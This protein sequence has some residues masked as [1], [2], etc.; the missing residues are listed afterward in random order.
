ML[1]AMRTSLP[2]SGKRS[3]AYFNDAIDRLNYVIVPS[4]LTSYVL[5]ISAHMF[6]FVGDEPVRCFAGP[7]LSKSENAFA[8][9]GCSHEQLA[10]YLWVPATLILQAVFFCLPYFLWISW[11]TH[12]GIDFK[13]FFTQ[14]VRLRKM[15][16][17]DSQRTHASEAIAK[18]VSEALIETP[19]LPFGRDLGFYATGLYA[20]V[21]LLYFLNVYMQ[22]VALNTFLGQ[23][24]PVFPTFTFCE[25]PVLRLGGYHHYTLHCHL[26]IND[27]NTKFYH[28]LWW[29]FLPVAFF[30]A[31]SLMYYLI[32]FLA[33]WTCERAVRHLLK[34]TRHRALVN[35]EDEKSRKLI[36]TFAECG[37]RRDGALLFWFI[38][39]EYAA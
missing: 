18:H 20:F 34:D 14:A 23:D 35:D 29:G 15:P 7:E 3:G 32:I 37:F 27:Y 39:G 4:V 30:N 2:D 13:A 1:V 11:R 28:F 24:S 21:K 6:G 16:P 12:S 8:V 31:T 9:G 17:S 25:F 33:P 10:D 19:N 38:E 22:F 26:P 5:F 36:R